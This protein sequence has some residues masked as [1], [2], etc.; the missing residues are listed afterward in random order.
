MS[1]A[2]ETS[3]DTTRCRRCHRALTKSAALGIGPRCAA[4]ESALADLNAGQQ[5]K[6]L[7]LIADGGIAPTSHK[8]V[9]R[10]ASSAGDAVYL[11]SV[12]GNC[13]C[14]HGL[15]TMTARPC[16]HAGAVRLVAK[17]RRSLAKAA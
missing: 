5:D 13:T 15:R 14:A 8:G 7:E 12:T 2:T 3:A 10:V 17:P 11:T 16:Y 4:I 6:A 9:Y 1:T